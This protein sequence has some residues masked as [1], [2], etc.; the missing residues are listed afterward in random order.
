MDPDIPLSQCIRI[1]IF[2]YKELILY[3]GKYSI[4][5]DIKDY[6]KRKRVTSYVMLDIIIKYNYI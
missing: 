4:S 2:T 3:G 1:Y 6:V 5:D